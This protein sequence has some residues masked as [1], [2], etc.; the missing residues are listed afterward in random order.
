VKL[1]VD[2]WYC[3]ASVHV[4]LRWPEMV[5]TDAEPVVHHAKAAEVCPDDMVMLPNEVVMDAVDAEVLALDVVTSA[6]AVYMSPN[7]VVTSSG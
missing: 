1:V 6:D 5:F 7:E 4:L 3:L 2:V